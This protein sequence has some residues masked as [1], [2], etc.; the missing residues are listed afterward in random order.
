[1][2][3]GLGH[4]KQIG[5]QLN[6]GKPRRNQTF[7]RM[8]VVYRPFNGV[9]GMS[10]MDLN[11]FVQ[12]FSCVQYCF[13]D[14]SIDSIHL[15]NWRYWWRLYHV[16]LISLLDWKNISKPA[17]VTPS[18]QLD[19]QVSSASRWQPAFPW[20]NECLVSLRHHVLAVTHWDTRL[21]GSQCLPQ[22]TANGFVCSCLLWTSMNYPSSPPK[23]H[24]F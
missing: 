4:S 16:F 8:L 11:K 12:Y 6:S 7:G 21:C 13:S 18:Q 14:M 5:T 17:P 1:M 22:Q 20:I 15:K 24:Q 23:N 19:C 9:S 10:K 2:G 3:G